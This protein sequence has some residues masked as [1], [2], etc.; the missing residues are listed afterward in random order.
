[1]EINSWTVKCAAEPTGQMFV[2]ENK[3]IL[4]CRL[5][6]SWAVNLN[7]SR[8]SATDRVQPPQLCIE[9]YDT[10]LTETADLAANCHWNFREH[11]PKCCFH[12]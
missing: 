5:S 9:F 7:A 11:V 2:Y 1:M 12:R 6:D 4:L 8:L 3:L 10:V